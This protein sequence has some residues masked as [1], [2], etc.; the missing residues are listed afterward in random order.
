MTIINGKATAQKVVERLTAQVQELKAQNKKVPHL[1]AVLVGTDGASLTYVGSKVRTCAKIGFEST[2]IELP[3]TTSQ[4]ELLEVVHNLNN[5]QAIDGYIVQLPLPKHINEAQIIE[6][7]DPKKD[8][9]GFHPINVG[10]MSIGMPCFLP[11]TPNGIMMLLKEY[12]IET[13]GK[14]CVVIG[15]S[16]IVGTPMSILLSRNS[17]PGN[18]TVTLV[19]SR[20]KNIEEYIQQADII[21]A[22]VGIPEFVKP[23]MV[24][25]GAVVIDVGI[26]RIQDATSPKGYVIKGDVEFDTVAPLCSAITPVPGGVG[27]MTIAALMQN[28]YI[29][30][31]QN[32]YQ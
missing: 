17:S 8:V 22:A 28:T 2:L 20:T 11:A 6:A 21:V 29:A 25:K 26:S 10:R 30:A 31:T 27:A 19:H 7:I 24:K 14:H 18:C 1:C 9:D 5:D 15:R 16:N 12:N 3:E 32:M 23:T 4:E 13:A